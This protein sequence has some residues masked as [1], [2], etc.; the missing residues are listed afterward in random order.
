VQFATVNST[1]IPV[2]FRPLVTAEITDNPDKGNIKG[3]SACRYFRSMAA[4]PNAS[5]FPGMTSF[6]GD[7]VAIC[8]DA[9]PDVKFMS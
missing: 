9:I 6:A 1:K 8:A 2:Q 4:A 3:T 5:H 7:A